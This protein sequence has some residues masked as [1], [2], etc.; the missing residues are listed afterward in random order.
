MIIQIMHWYQKSRNLPKLMLDGVSIFAPKIRTKMVEYQ[1]FDM[2]F[3]LGE[4]QHL[5]LVVAF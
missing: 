5:H 1:I 3:C 4:K 2:P